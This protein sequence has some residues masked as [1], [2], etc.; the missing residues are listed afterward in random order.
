MRINSDVLYGIV[1]YIRSIV[2]PNRDHTMENLS[3]CIVIDVYV[4]GARLR[5]TC[6]MC[7]CVRWARR[8][9]RLWLA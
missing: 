6:L 3:R 8:D 4:V 5:G 2:W 9:L 7:I 1:L